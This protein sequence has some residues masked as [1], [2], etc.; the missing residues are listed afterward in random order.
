[1][2]NNEEHKIWSHPHCV[3]WDVVFNLSKSYLLT[4]NNN[5]YLVGLL[6]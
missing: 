6:Q 2:S 4:R 1:M 5:T 3:I